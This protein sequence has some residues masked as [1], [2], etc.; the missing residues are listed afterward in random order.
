MGSFSVVPI[1]VM[2]LQAR[3]NYYKFKQANKVSHTA[4]LFSRYNTTI[5]VSQNHWKT[6]AHILFTLLCDKDSKHKV[7]DD[8]FIL[9]QLP[10]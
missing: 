5:F 2:E 6:G 10:F 8:F 1:N 7:L 9:R 4:P 3:W